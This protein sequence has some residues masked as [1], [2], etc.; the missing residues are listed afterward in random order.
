MFNSTLISCPNVAFEHACE[1]A[2]REFNAVHGSPQWDVQYPTTGHTMTDEELDIIHDMEN[3]DGC[4]EWR[5]QPDG[6][7]SCPDCSEPVED[8]PACGNCEG[9]LDCLGEPE[10]SRFDTSEEMAEFYREIY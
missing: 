7:C 4:Q 5:T 9:C 2:T 1:M 3:E 8:E 10:E 6:F